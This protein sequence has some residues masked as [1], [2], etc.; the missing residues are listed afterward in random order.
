MGFCR[1][2]KQKSKLFIMLI[3]YHGDK[4][5]SCAYVLDGVEE[6]F[7]TTLGIGISKGFECSAEL[8]AGFISLKEL[9]IWG[10]KFTHLECPANPADSRPR[11][12]TP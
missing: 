2:G 4:K 7:K 11:F 3:G 9:M 10:L 1:V 8:R 5:L 12:L 6:T